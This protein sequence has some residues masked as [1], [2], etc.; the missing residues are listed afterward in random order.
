M[1]FTRRILGSARSSNSAP[2]G[3]TFSEDTTRSWEGSAS[4]RSLPALPFPRFPVGRHGYNKRVTT[5]NHAP[6]TS[7]VALSEEALLDPSA[8]ENL[9]PNDALPPGAHKVKKERSTNGRDAPYEEAP[10]GP[11]RHGDKTAN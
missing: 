7:D 10:T 3:P 2:S 5:R 1:G 11:G 6:D 4:S 9:D 8:D